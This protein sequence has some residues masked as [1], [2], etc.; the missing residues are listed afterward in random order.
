MG[1]LSAAWL[2]RCSVAWHRRG[3]PSIE[4]RGALRAAAAAASDANSMINLVR[5]LP[6]LAAWNLTKRSAPKAEKW[7]W[8]STSRAAASCAPMC[9][10]PDGR[11]TCTRAAT[12]DASTP[13]DASTE[14][15]C[16][17][18]VGR[19][20]D[21]PPRTPIL[22]AQPASLARSASFSASIRLSRIAIASSASST[23]WCD[24]PC[25]SAR[26]TT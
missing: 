18:A 16:A 8:R 14:R 9:N 5:P 13:L 20:S 23:A 2:S 22:P 19:R 10:T 7:R 26:I 17:K 15:P 25:T 21:A 12:L 4:G 3:E 24:A 1:R 6:G 11:G